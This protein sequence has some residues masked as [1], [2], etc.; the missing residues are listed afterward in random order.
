M[1][2]PTVHRGSV[3]EFDD[4]AGLGVVLGDDGVEHRFHCT[5]LTDGTRTVPVG[6]RVAYEVVPARDGRSEAVAV[7]PLGVTPPPVAP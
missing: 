4:P 5:S 7:T 3:T 1:A 2:R 6:A